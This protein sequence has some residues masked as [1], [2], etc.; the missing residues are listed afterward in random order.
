M[1]P[2]GVLEGLGMGRQATSSSRA[3]TG[4]LIASLLPEGSVLATQPCPCLHFCS[5]LSTQRVA[6]A[7]ATDGRTAGQLSTLIC[8]LS[9]GGLWWHEAG[10]RLALAQDSRSPCAHHFMSSGCVGTACFKSTVRRNPNSV[11]PAKAGPAPDPHELSSVLAW[12][13]VSPV[14][15]HVVLLQPSWAKSDRGPPQ[16]LRGP[17]SKATGPHDHLS[18][19]SSAEKEAQSRKC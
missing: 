15:F 3:S 4:A 11:C 17:G 5:A 7:G 16:G 19:V 2:P 10:G 6:G 12:A 13:A 9:A 1:V 18:V 14:D 8:A